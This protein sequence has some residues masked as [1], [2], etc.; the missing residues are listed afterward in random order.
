[1]FK[2]VLVANRGEIA[3][4]IIRACRDLGMKTVAV[5]SDADR[6]SL[7]VAMADEAYNIGPPAPGESYLSIPKIIDVIKRSGAEAVHPGYGFLSENATFAETCEKEG[8]V[9]IGPT[10][11][12][13]RLMGDKITARGIARE[14]K[15]PLVPGSGGA[16]SDVEAEITAK[17]I[18]YPVMIKA[19]AGGGG[20]GMRLVRKEED[21]KSSLRMARSEATSAFG[22]DSVYIEKFIERPRHVEIQILGDSHGNVVH[23]F[24]RECSIQRRHQKV[25]EEAPSSAIGEKTRKKMGEVAVRIA[26]AVSYRGAGTVEFILDQ[27]GNFYFLEMNTR[28]Q[29]EHP[30]TEVITGINIVRAMIRAA[31]EEKLPFTQEDI[32]IRGHA[33]ECRVYA[34]DPEKNF[35]P[36]PG[37]IEYVR[38]PSGP[39]LRDDTSIYSGCEITPFYDPMLS[40]VIAWGHSRKNAIKKMRTALLEYVVLGV[41]TNLGFLLRVMENEEFIQGEIDTGFIER[42]P[43]LL[44]PSLNNIEPALIAAALTVRNSTK[45]IAASGQTPV[46]NWK[47]FSRK[48]A[49]SRNS[50]L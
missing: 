46:S 1:M 40:K 30:V 50:V 43:E 2:K 32:S 8:I 9:F 26:K 22:D 41:K 42:H 29:V 12:A 35:L 37:K 44:S 45:E 27:D 13:I 47:L 6:R 28:I 19:S 34:E 36:S 24:E 4:R 14:A 20:K 11:E 31:T 16:V 38:A 33:I 15:V 48:L 25:I 17:K 21:F 3:V 7:H 18:G 10:S 5:Y 49:L 23:L 39:F